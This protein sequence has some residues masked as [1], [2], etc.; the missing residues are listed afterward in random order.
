M[1]GQIEE[2]YRLPLVPMGARNRET[3]RATMKGCGVLK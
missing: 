2:E 1:M 3:L